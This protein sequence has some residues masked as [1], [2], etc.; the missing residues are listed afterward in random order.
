MSRTS[1]WC[2]TM[3]N[4]A[5]ILADGTARTGGELLPAF[6]GM[7]EHHRRSVLG[8][9]RRLGWLRREPARSGEPSWHF[10][11]SL[12]DNDSWRHGEVATLP[13]HVDPCNLVHKAIAT[14]AYALQ[15]R[16]RQR[17]LPRVDRRHAV[18]LADG[19]ADLAVQLFVRALDSDADLRAAVVPAGGRR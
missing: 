16:N 18:R 7:D 19:A 2:A 13:N 5:A 11:Y 4:I 9:F 14:T 15:L 1:T 3:G 10:R 6:A 12:G 17:R 8:R